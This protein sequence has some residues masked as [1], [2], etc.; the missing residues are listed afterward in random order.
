MLNFHSTFWLLMIFWLSLYEETVQISIGNN[1]KQKS[2][3]KSAL[4]ITGIL[5]GLNDTLPTILRVFGSNDIDIY[6]A[7][8][9]KDSGNAAEVEGLNNLLRD[10]R[11]RNY[12]IDNISSLTESILP[13]VPSFPYQ[14]R[15]PSAN[16]VTN[17]ISLYRWK[18]GVDM[19]LESG[20]SYSW[21]AKVRT[22]SFFSVRTYPIKFEDLDRQFYGDENPAQV[23]HITPQPRRIIHPLAFLSQ[24]QCVS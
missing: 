18:Q 23:F 22:D 7:G 2:H 11:L 3:L 13:F 19:I 4:L 16:Q 9:F 8:G 21:I 6:F 12:K 5:R 15:W 10:P 14:Q 17:I 20:V 1:I 24:N